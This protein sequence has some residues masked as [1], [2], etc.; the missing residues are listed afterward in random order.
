[1]FEEAVRTS[2]AMEKALGSGPRPLVPALCGCLTCE[3]TAMISAPRLGACPECGRD[4]V[5]L[6]EGEARYVRPTGDEEW[7]RVA[8]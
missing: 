1:M 5:V 3:T 4:M 7:G 8:A 6:S 2:E